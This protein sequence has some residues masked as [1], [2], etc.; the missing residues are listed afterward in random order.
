MLFVFQTANKERDEKVRPIRNEME[1][2]GHHPLL[3]FF[4]HLG[5][6]DAVDDVVSGRSS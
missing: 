1:R 2:R 4:K 6:M 5:E 3:F